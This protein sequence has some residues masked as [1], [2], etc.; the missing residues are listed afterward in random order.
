MFFL[1]WHPARDTFLF[2]L[3][4]NTQMYDN[5][6]ASFLF[7]PFNFFS[8]FHGSTLAFSFESSHLL[9]LIVHLLYASHDFDFDFDL[10]VLFGLGSKWWCHRGRWRHTM[11]PTISFPSCLIAIE[12]SIQWLEFCNIKYWET[13][14]FELRPPGHCRCVRYLQ[15]IAPPCNGAMFF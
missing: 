2:S 11:L 3:F 15:T 13:T 5:K 8:S 12:I 7:F 10:T 4:F 9:L 14:G 6:V 1:S